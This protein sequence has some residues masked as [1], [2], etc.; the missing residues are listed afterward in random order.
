MTPVEVKRFVNSLRQ[1]IVNIEN[2]PMPVIAA[3]DGQ[4][5]GGAK[6]TSSLES[7]IMIRLHHKYSQVDLN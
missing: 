1:L 3:I 6:M 2:L 5:L 4:A 7:T